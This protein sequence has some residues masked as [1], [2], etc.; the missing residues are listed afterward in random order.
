MR[1]LVVLTADKQQRE[2]MS[3]LLAERQ[4][5]INIAVGTWDCFRHPGSDP[6]VYNDGAA[7]LS[8]FRYQYHRAVVLLDREWQGGPDDAGEMRDHLA[9]AL[10]AAG[11]DGRCHVVVPDPEF[12]VWVFGDSPHVAHIL[13]VSMEALRALGAERGWWPVDH[14]KPSRPKELLE[15]ILR[16]A[17]KPRSSAL[18]VALARKV[19][20]SRCTDPA[21]RLLCDTLRAWFPAQ[22]HQP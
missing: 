16:S 14:P 10:A 7:Y 17:R 15:D 12:D 22:S 8:T 4:R 18:Y 6:G 11:W 9:S 20:L 21:F 13:G 5:A 19:S 2:T 1:D 3:A